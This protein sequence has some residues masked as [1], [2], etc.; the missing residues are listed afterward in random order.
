MPD[1]ELKITVVGAEDSHTDNTTTDSTDESPKAWFEKKIKPLQDTLELDLEVVRPYRPADSKQLWETASVSPSAIQ[2]SIHFQVSSVGATRGYQTPVSTSL[3][4]F[5]VPINVSHTISSTSQGI[6]VRNVLFN[7]LSEPIWIVSANFVSNCPEIIDDSNNGTL[8]PTADSLNDGISWP[9]RLLPHQQMALV[10]RVVPEM[11]C[12]LSHLTPSSFGTQLFRCTTQINFSVATKPSQPGTSEPLQPGTSEPL[13]FN[14]PMLFESPH[15]Q[16]TCDIVSPDKTAQPAVGQLSE[17]DVVIKCSGIG[18]EH[19]SQPSAN[20]TTTDNNDDQRDNESDSSLQH[21][22]QQERK[23]HDDD[24]A[25]TLSYAVMVD[26]KTWMASGKVRGLVDLSQE[27]KFEYRHK[28]LLLPLVP[29]FLKLPRVKLCW[30]R[31]SSASVK[32]IPALDM[33]SAQ[34]VRVVPGFEISTVSRLALF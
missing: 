15:L 31:V 4:S 25:L 32:E 11:V 30:Q 18:F 3:V 27:N 22:Q 10:W 12:S 20:F 7:M 9:V 16:F 1:N 26:Q 14:Y 34:Q 23:Q 24:E 5:H 2:K 33:S 13:Q 28:V 8:H 29:G 6:Y 21:Q 19:S 17:F